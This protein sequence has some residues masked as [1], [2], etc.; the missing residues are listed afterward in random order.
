MRL[1]KKCRYALR[2]L[3]DLSVCSTE[4]HVVLSTI[5]ERNGISPQYLE[6]AFAGLRRGGIV[7]GIKGSQGGYKLNRNPEQITVA[8]ILESLDGTYQIEREDMQD[9]S[10]GRNISISIQ[11]IVIDRVNRQLDEVLQA[12]TLEELKNRF[13]D[14]QETGQ[15]MYYI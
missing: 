1:S 12:T 5:A 7:K 14:L 9:D 11:E 6:Q 8:D 4:E 15:D 2:A 10:R 13:L 3:I